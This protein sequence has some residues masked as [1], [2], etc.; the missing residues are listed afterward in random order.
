MTKILQI[1]CSEP[2]MPYTPNRWNLNFKQCYKLSII[3]FKLRSQSIPVYV[4]LWRDWTYSDQYNLIEPNPQHAS[5]YIKRT[6]AW[7]RWDIF[8]SMEAIWLSLLLPY[9][10]FVIPSFELRDCYGL[11]YILRLNFYSPDT[12]SVFNLAFGITDVFIYFCDFLFSSL[13]FVDCDHM[14]VSQCKQYQ[15]Q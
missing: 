8:L 6:R 1:S 2:S 3:S 9:W 11:I 10:W 12:D 13:D 4:I 15:L 7:D 5:I 14:L